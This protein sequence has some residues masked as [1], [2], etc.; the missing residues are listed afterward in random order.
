MFIYTD[1]PWASGIFC[2]PLQNGHSVPPPSSL[3]WV[4]GIRTQVLMLESF[5]KILSFFAMFLYK[6]SVE[7]EILYTVDVLSIVT[8]PL[9]VN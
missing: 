6:S 3:A 2:Q 7:E 9:Y 1:W 5:P 4:P 8:E